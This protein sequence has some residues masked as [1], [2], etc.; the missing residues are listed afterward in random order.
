VGIDRLSRSQIGLRVAAAAAAAVVV[1]VVVVVVA[2]A[3]M[4]HQSLINSTNRPMG[5]AMEY[6]LKI[7][8]EVSARPPCKLP[9]HVILPLVHSCMLQR[10]IGSLI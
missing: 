6:R 4:L 9:L 1:V 3:A 8:W 10:W 5:L 2:A 7:Q